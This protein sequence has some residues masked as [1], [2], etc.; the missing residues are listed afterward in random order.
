M[1]LR[2]YPSP[3]A[4]TA[5]G[6]LFVFHIREHK[7][8]NVTCPALKDRGYPVICEKRY[9]QPITVAYDG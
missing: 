4:A 2:P 5:G 6:V 3:A 1:P 9:A 7:D 8:F